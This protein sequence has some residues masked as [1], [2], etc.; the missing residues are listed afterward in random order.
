LDFNFL[1]FNDE[2]PTFPTPSFFLS[3]SFWSCFEPTGI[4]ENQ[5]AIFEPNPS[6]E[7]PPAEPRLLEPSLAPIKGIQVSR[8]FSESQRAFFL[9]ELAKIQLLDLPV[10]PVP[11]DTPF[12]T[13]FFYTE[14][15]SSFLKY[16]E[17]LPLTLIDLYSLLPQDISGDSFIAVAIGSERFQY[18]KQLRSQYQHQPNIFNERILTLSHEFSGDPTVPYRFQFNHVIALGKL[19]DYSAEESRYARIAGL[20]T[21]LLHELQHF[22]GSAFNHQLCTSEDLERPCDGVS[23]GPYSIT[24]PIYERLIQGCLNQKKIRETGALPCL[25]KDLGFLLA[26]HAF[27]LESSSFGKDLK[28]GPARQTK[29]LT[30]EPL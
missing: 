10:L 15:L 28:N 3:C 30:I 5:E 12:G 7:A 2:T 9:Q 21:T 23:N 29:G 16:F 8:F 4:E 11:K 27:I 14:K 18:I 1:L 26:E 24:V 22:Q 25:E 6:L 20:F 13:A 17:T 19:F